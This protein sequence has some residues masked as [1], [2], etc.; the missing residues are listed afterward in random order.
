MPLPRT[1]CSAGTQLT[2]VELHR[3]SWACAR[4]RC[5][6]SQSSS[7]HSTRARGAVRSR[8]HYGALQRPALTPCADTRTTPDRP[9]SETRPVPRPSD[10][11]AELSCRS[12][13]RGLPETLGKLSLAVSDPPYFDYIS[14]SDLSLFFRAWHHPSGRAHALRGA[15]IY[16]VGEDAPA[17]FEARL[18][19]A[20]DKVRRQLRRGAILCFT[21]HSTNADAWDALGSALRRAHFVAV[22]VFPVWA[23]AKAGSHSHSGNCEWDLVF[24][25]RK[26]PARGDGGVPGDDRRLARSA[27]AALGLRG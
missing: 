2:T 11:P 8:P 10:R 14:Y 25:C 27:R 12:A 16:P 7:T 4:T 13:D 22:A 6:C 21:F 15:P 17:T 20:F 5:P 19:G 24:V 9:K 18:A 3:C 23:D 26:R 1:T